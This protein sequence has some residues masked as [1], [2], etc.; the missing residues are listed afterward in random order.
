MGKL[1]NK[2]LATFLICALF[3]IS[4]PSA[5]HADPYSEI[6]GK[7]KE[8]QTKEKIIEL[9]GKPLAKKIIIKSS[10]FIWGPEE[11]FWDK[12]PMETQLEVWEY[13]FSDGHL[14]LYFINAGD[15]LDYKAF[16]PKG[17]VY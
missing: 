6:E 17:V 2:L 16:A 14:N 15:R 13:Q 10:R 9:L 7:L 8:G 3:I 4:P 12:I 5:S 1:S 11:E